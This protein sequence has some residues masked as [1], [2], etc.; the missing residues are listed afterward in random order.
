VDASFS[1]DAA[2]PEQAANLSPV[3]YACVILSDVAGVPA[4][5]EAALKK[6][7]EAG[8]AVLVALGPA[9]ATRSRVPVYGEAIRQS[10][11]AQRQ[12]ERFQSVG[13]LD[14]TH[15]SIHRAN[16]WEGVKFYQTVLF[17]AGTGRVV[18]R[19]A[20]QSPLLAEKRL[21]AG[22]VL[23]FGS[24]FDN[25][26]NDF[27]LH[28]SFV[29]FVEQT[30]NYLAGYDGRPPTH[31]V[32]SFAEL[33]T[34]KQRGEALEVLDPAGRR[35]L[36]LEEAATLETLQLRD[37]GFYEIRRPNGRREVLAVNADRQE[38]DLDVLPPET[39]SVW[40]ATGEAT[41]TA[42]VDG[43]GEKSS[44]RL[45]WYV[46][47]AAVAVAIVESVFGQ[48]YLGPVKESA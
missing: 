1:I 47:A 29:P 16:R 33:R 46:L 43:E 20:D 31:L 41:R 9:A 17:D 35:A 30:T 15:P 37:E 44:F 14:P 48:K 6:H 5:F 28:A 3:N 34:E 13:P 36:S 27:P 4:A 39:L 12:N 7:V 2:T 26:S 45:W 8:G 19:L 38:S 21:G 18:V 24:T 11:Y 25:L 40:Q 22:K 32:D 42:G 23:V 10:R